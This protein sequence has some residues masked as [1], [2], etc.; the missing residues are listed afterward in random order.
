MNRRNFIQNT[1]KAGLFT[2]ISLLPAGNLLAKNSMTETQLT[3]LHT[4]DTHSQIFPFEN[5]SGP[6]AGMGGI[7]SRKKIIEQI[8]G[9]GNP[10]LLLDAG[11]FCD[12]SSIYDA[13]KGKVE[14]EAMRLLGYDAFTLGEKDFLGGIDNLATQLKHTGMKPIVCNYDFTH[15]SLQ[16]WYQPYT[17]IQKE[18][19]KIGVL[20]VLLPLHDKISI[21]GIENLVYL[22]AV[23]QANK[24]AAILQQQ[25]CDIIICLSHLGDRYADGRISDEVLAKNNQ[26]IDVIIGGHTHQF[27]KQPRLYKNK[28]SSYTLVNQA[29]W[30]GIQMG[31]LDYVFTNTTN[32]KLIRTKN[33]LLREKKNE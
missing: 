30:G 29:G 20:G 18:N 10:A 3:I 24:T 8:R 23:I 2:G 5:N 4:N 25:H 1:V 32:K 13:Y 14:L 17:I 7:E 15:T 12:D 9:T 33:I 28:S 26:C 21:S 31:Q 22:D 27:F 19:L 16:N 6:Y 11:D